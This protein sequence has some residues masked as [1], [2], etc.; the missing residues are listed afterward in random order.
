[1]FDQY[2]YSFTQAERDAIE[3]PSFKCLSYQKVLYGWEVTY[4]LDHPCDDVTVVYDMDE[5]SLERLQKMWYVKAK[6]FNDVF[7][8]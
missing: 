2:K 7:S 6:Y 3:C 1:M 8:V 5:Y 4:Y